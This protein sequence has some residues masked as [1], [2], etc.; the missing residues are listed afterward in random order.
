M[1]NFFFGGARNSHPAG[2]R[3][4]WNLK[5][6]QSLAREAQVKRNQRAKEYH[7]VAWWVEGTRLCQDAP[8][9][10]LREGITHADEQPHRYTII[11][12]PQLAASSI[13]DACCLVHEQH[14]GNKT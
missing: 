5:G 11:N 13:P 7:L 2:L 9:A 4:F 12:P 14:M 10:G 3:D 6:N 8:N 1:E